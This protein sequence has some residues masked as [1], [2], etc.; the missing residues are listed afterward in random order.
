MRIAFDV[1][2]T[3]SFVG[4]PNTS[5]RGSYFYIWTVPVV[6]PDSIPTFFNDA[7]IHATS[8]SPIILAFSSLFRIS[9]TIS[10]KK[11]TYELIQVR[12]RGPEYGCYM[13]R[14]QRVLQE[15]PGPLR[16]L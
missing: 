11:N 8:R 9:Y 1:T 4:E 6:D 10:D 2:A 3:A 12:K 16:A 14:T 13:F 7:I 5:I 15:A